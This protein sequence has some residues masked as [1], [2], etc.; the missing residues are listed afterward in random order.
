NVQTKAAAQ[1]P[2]TVHVKQTI[3]EAVR[4]PQKV[5]PEKF[6]VKML[7]WVT[8]AP[9]QKSVIYTAL[10]KL[11]TRSLPKGTPKR[12][13]SDEKNS[14][15]YPS[16]SADGKSIVY[17][18]WNDEDKG[19]IWKVSSSGGKGTKLTQKPGHYIQ[20]HFSP[21]GKKIVYNRIG[22]DGTRGN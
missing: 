6:D 15:L 9:D 1:I 11:W 20:P 5:A 17:A 7:R 22:G 3:T 10:G 4:F 12:L 19:G 16:F 18:T 21:D 8:V 2:F 13:T 14:E